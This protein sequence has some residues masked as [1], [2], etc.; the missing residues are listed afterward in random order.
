LFHRKPK[1]D[2]FPSANDDMVVKKM[3]Q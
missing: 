2:S 3:A 1:G